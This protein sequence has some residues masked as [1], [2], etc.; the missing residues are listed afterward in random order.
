ME[1]L[2]ERL[3]RGDQRALARAISLVEDRAPGYQELVDAVF[4]HTGK[5]WQIGITGAPGVGKSSLVDRLAALFRDE[6]KKVGIIAC[7]PTSPFTHGALLG[8]RIRMR[9][10]AQDEHV[11]IRSMATRGARGGLAGATLEAALLLEAAGF[12]IVILET[13]GVGQAELDVVEAADTVVVVLT[14]QSGDAIQAMKAGLMEIADIFVLNKADLAGSDLA[15][16]NLKSVLEL[17]PEGRR[18][19]IVETVATEGKGLDR[20]RAALEEHWNYLQ[21][22]EF[23]G[24]RRRRLKALLQRIV[25][26][27]LSERL[28]SSARSLDGRIDELLAHKATPYRVAQEVLLELGNAGGSDN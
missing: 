10:I 15:Y 1:D 20:L 9:S 11:F 23:E 14:P 18:P 25:T 27:A 5:A 8:D 24:R 6:G 12:E 28:W 4:P 3:L 19:P 16:Q 21:Q 7:D 13:I 17:A 2:I 22:G 26:E